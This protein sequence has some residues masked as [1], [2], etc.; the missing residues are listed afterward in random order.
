MNGPAARPTTETLLAHVE[1]VRRLARLLVAN[2]HDADDVEQETWRRALERP[3]G[4][5]H[6][7]RHWFAAVV[8]NVARKKGRTE[9]ARERHEHQAATSAS[10]IFASQRS[11]AGEAAHDVT[12]RAE[13]HRKVVDAVLTLEELYRTPLLL[14]F[15]DDLSAAEVATRLGVPVETARTRIKRGLALLRARL[16]V[17]FGTDGREGIAALL[18]LAVG[19]KGAAAIAAAAA[20][21]AAVAVGGTAATVGGGLSGLVVGGAVMSNLT[22]VAIAL[23]VAA[24]ACVG[25]YEVWLAPRP[26]RATVAKSATK[27]AELPAPAIATPPP[28]ELPSPVT[29]A[30]RETAERAAPSE[31]PTPATTLATVDG[32]VLDAGGQPVAEARVFLDRRASSE[33]TALRTFRA[34]CRFYENNESQAKKRGFKITRSGPDGSFRFVDVDP[35]NAW[36]IGAVQD[37]RGTGWTDAIAFS[38]TP[39]AAHVVVSLEAGVILFGTVFDPAGRPVEGAAVTIEGEKKATNDG[40]FNFWSELPDNIYTGEDG[41]YRTNAL[42]WRFVRMH[43]LAQ[44]RPELAQLE[45]KFEELPDGAIEVRRDLTMEALTTLRGRIVTADGQPARLAQTVVP[46][47]GADATR[48]QSHETIAVTAFADDPRAHQDSIAALGRN[49]PELV[50]LDADRAYG[51]IELAEDRYEVALRSAQLRFIALIAR[52][53]I[54]GVAEIPTPPVGPDLVVNLS[55]LPAQSL[56]HSLRLHLRDARDHSPLDE[57]RVHGIAITKWPNGGLGM[58]ILDLGGSGAPEEGPP[59]RDLILPLM[60]CTVFMSKPGFATRSLAVDASRANA[61][62]EQTVELEPAA[63]AL[64]LR[65][66][67]PGGTPITGAET[68]CYRAADHEAARGRAPA[69]DERGESTLTGFAAGGLLVVVEKDGYAAAAA[70]VTI[71]AEESEAEVVLE[72]GYEVTLSV[73]GADGKAASYG[74]L[75]LTNEAGVPLYDQFGGDHGPTRLNGGKF[76]LTDGTYTVRCQIPGG[77]GATQ[78]FVAAPGAIVDVKLGPEH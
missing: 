15:F 38:G 28:P 30:T 55:L 8:R 13:L 71:G 7:L 64:R 74:Q 3:P 73:H 32:V 25:A 42:P 14:R 60:P 62:K 33:M 58:E 34:S 69:T 70:T 21:G 6:S 20:G 53:R 31:K 24:V 49:H 57:V 46:Q 1:W 10:G 77:D 50:S 47:L 27:P 35:K 52:D 63:A 36:A 23:G 41:T 4:S 68:S 18:P 5:S 22:K 26:E 76:R 78:K 12:A 9:E 40:H 44:G 43:V 65:V 29:A 37:P 45:T 19:G 16:G 72:R 61:P 56:L 59:D 39:A 66:I 54:L 2:V 67:D 48:I 17:E 75:L 11:T 51:K